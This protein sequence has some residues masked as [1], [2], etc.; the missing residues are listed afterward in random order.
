MNFDMRPKNLHFFVWGTVLLF[1]FLLLLFLETRGIFSSFDLGITVAVQ[2]LIP[3]L[4]D[5]PMSLFTLLGNVEF[6][7]LVLLAIGYWVFRREK[8]I[9]Y[10]LIL[11]GVIGAFEVIGKLFLYHPGPPVELFR[12]S[13]PFKFPHLYLKTS[14]SFPSGH[15]SRT[16]F[17]AVLSLFLA[18]RYIKNYS[19]KMLVSCTLYLVAFLMVLSRVYLGEHWASDVLGGILLGGSMGLLALVYY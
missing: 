19:K 8:R 9:Y 12:F 16:T 13:L 17:L 1:S 18:A 3:R 14:Y 2:N 6:T 10:P 5:T 15:V 7:A 11:F 4:L